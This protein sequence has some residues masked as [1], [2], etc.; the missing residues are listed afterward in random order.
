[1]ARRVP[2]AWVDAR[3][4]EVDGDGHGGDG[5]EGG[6]REGVQSVFHGSREGEVMVE[7]RPR[8]EFE[9]MLFKVP[10]PG[11]TLRAVDVEEVEV[12]IT[13]TE[14]WCKTGLT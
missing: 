13:I 7:G 11:K 2:L 9:R 6:P 10:A 4:F 14:G 3:L 12:S 1:V 5:G 8:C